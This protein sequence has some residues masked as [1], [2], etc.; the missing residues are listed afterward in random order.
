MSA[1]LGTA[2]RAAAT[3]KEFNGK[4]GRVGAVAVVADA[5]VPFLSPLPLLL[6][7][8]VAPLTVAVKKARGFEPIAAFRNERPSRPNCPFGDTKE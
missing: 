6:D 2:A 7:D 8:E 3:N 1:G 4:P 5:L